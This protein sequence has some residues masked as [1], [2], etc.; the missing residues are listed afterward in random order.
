MGATSACSNFRQGNVGASIVDS[1]GVALDAT[2]AA[3][4]FVPASTGKAIKAARGLEKA[5]DGART[6]DMLG[7]AAKMDGYIPKPPTGPGS[8]PVEQR[9]PHRFS[10]IPYENPS[11]L[12]KMESARLAAGR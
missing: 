1:I 2:A 8:V 10:P 9:D 5:V 12:N 7:G 4:P 3:V 6:A 11:E